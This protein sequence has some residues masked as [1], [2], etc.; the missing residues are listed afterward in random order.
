MPARRCVRRK[1][2]RSATRDPNR[3]A[4]QLFTELREA[5][6]V[7]RKN[8]SV[9]LRRCG[10]KERWAG[11]W[12]F[13][14]F[15]VEASGPLFAKREIAEKVEAQTGIACEPGALFKTLR[16]GVT[17]FRITLDCYEAAYL[18]AARVLPT[19]AQ[20]AGNHNHC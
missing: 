20:C 10:E 18:T 6:V 14:R 15:E 5:A 4:T 16:H 11:L 8:G 2:R 7:V 19:S 13:P 17:R 3:Q 9:L 12:D 1:C